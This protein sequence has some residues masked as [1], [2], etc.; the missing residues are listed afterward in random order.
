VQVEHV[1]VAPEGH[2]QHAGLAVDDEADVGQVRLV[3]DGVDHLP[4]EA[5]AVGLA[6]HARAIGLDQVGRRRHDRH[7]GSRTPMTQDHYLG[8]RRRAAEGSVRSVR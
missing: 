4:V 1:A 3:E 2:G 7:G 8:G 5:A 6:P